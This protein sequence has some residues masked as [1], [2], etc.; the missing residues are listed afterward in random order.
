MTTK[1]KAQKLCDK[2]KA[3]KKFNTY[4][5]YGQK[6]KRN[7]LDSIKDYTEQGEALE[8]F[9]KNGFQYMNK[10]PFY[11]DFTRWQSKRD[12]KKHYKKYW[13]LVRAVFFY[14]ILLGLSLLLI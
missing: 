7:F 8:V 12:R 11:N 5:N 3:S 13:S 9:N 4:E 2:L 14:G 1:E 6:E 10:N